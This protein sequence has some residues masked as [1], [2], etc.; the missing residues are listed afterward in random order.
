MKNDEGGEIFMYY[1]SSF[2]LKFRIWNVYLL[3]P[4]VNHF[5][6]LEVNP[7]H[8]DQKGLMAFRI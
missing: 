2:D 4:C 5:G 6:L 1:I 7:G 8:P 3:D